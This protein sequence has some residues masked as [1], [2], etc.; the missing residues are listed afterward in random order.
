LISSQHV[1][2]MVCYLLSTL[3]EPIPKDKILQV[4]IN[5]EI[6]NYFEVVQ[7]IGDLAD[8]GSIIRVEGEGE[9]YTVSEKGKEAIDE[10]YKNLP[11]TVREKAIKAGLKMLATRRSKAQNKVEME[12]TDIGVNV[13]CSIID[14]DHPILTVSL[15]VPDME[16]AKLVKETFHENTL[17]IYSGSIA[18]LTGDYKSVKEQF[19][20]E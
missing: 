12:Q 8:N 3:K 7:A 10:L 17:K 16:Q 4:L 6:A 15:L 18:L 20:A 19:E 13:T 9:L 5:E 2:Q 11:F 14:G 1:R